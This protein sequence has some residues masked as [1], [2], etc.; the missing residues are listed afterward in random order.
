MDLDK[1]KAYLASRKQAES[2]HLFGVPIKL[3]DTPTVEEI[4]N[5]KK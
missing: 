3:H 5:I 2:G 4:Q 1:L